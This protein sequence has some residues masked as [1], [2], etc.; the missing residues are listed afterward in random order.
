[1][2]D[3]E[4]RYAFTNVKPSEVEIHIERSFDSDRQRIGASMRLNAIVEPKRVTVVDFQTDE[5]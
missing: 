4:G 2:T 1:M 3:A 5:E